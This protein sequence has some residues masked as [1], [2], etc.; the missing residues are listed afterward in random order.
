VGLDKARLRQFGRAYVDALLACDERAAENAVREAMD[1][2]LSTSEIDDAI[3]APALSLV[4]ELWQRG[5]IS[6]AD[7]HIATE[8][9]IRVLALQREAQRV[10]ED[11]GVH[12]V[13]CAAPAGERHVVALRMAANLLHGAGYDVV[14]LGADVPADALGASARRHEPDVICMSLTLSGGIERM[15]SSIEAAR[16]Q[17]PEVGF[18]LGGCGLTGQVQLWPEV[19][20]CRRVSDV[21]EVVDAIVKRASRN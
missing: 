16:R 1:A 5:E 9:S 8:I 7:E 4:G 15:A 20:V 2:K 12:R 13:M 11:R 21:I 19:R 6:I 14:M 3:I 18:A 17:C 10:A